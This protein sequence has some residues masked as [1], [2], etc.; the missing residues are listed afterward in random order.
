MHLLLANIPPPSG[1]ALGDWLIT[2]AAVGSAYLV[3]KKIFARK[4]GDFTTRTEFQQEVSALRDKIDARFLTLSEKIESLGAAIN[5]RL[6]Q[7][8]AGLA[9]VDERTRK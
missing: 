5:Q 6:A 1:P 2:G 4:P 9:R 8:E 7:I 3:F